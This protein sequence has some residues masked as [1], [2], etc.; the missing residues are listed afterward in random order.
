MWSSIHHISSPSRGGS[1][2]R[3]RVGGRGIVRQVQQVQ[4]QPTPETIE[5]DPVKD[6]WVYD[7]AEME[8]D[9]PLEPR[10][11]TGSESPENYRR[12]A[13]ILARKIGSVTSNETGRCELDSHAD[14]C[15][16]G[17]DAMVLEVY[18]GQRF[19]VYG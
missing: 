17:R 4:F 3:G 19:Q 2:A 15:M 13:T 12:I 16:L 7:A 9:L 10:M 6:E 5:A 14:N 1:S 18:E 8:E 11:S